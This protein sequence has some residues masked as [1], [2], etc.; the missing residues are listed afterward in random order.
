MTSRGQGGITYAKG[1]IDRAQ[2]GAN[3]RVTHETLGRRFTVVW[4]LTAT[5][6]GGSHAHPTAADPRHCPCA[7]DRGL[8]HLGGLVPVAISHDA[9]RFGRSRY[10]L[11]EEQ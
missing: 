2:L 9:F 5:C 1:L 4:P 10:I 6:I 7:L 11:V 8:R 3:N